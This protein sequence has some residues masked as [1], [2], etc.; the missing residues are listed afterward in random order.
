MQCGGSTVKTPH[1]RGLVRYT[2]GLYVYANNA[3]TL[4]VSGAGAQM[5]TLMKITAHGYA[6]I[7]NQTA[8]SYSYSTSIANILDRTLINIICDDW[9]M[10]AI[11]Y[12]MFGDQHHPLHDDNLRCLPDGLPK[13]FL[14]ACAERNIP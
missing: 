13:A 4:T 10:Q 9:E 8:N 14:T 2:V 12:I 6:V 11:V 3:S 5:K 1:T 7:F